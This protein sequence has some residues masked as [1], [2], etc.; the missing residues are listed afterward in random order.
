[1]EISTGVGVVPAPDLKA[2]GAAVAA[3]RRERGF[4]LDALAEAS[5][6]SRKSLINV[7][8]AH[9][10]ARLDTAHAIAHALGMPLSPLVDSLCADH[11]TPGHPA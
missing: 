3:A 9:K 10:I 11:D 7:E 5:G 4:S 6:V 1:M 8:K 2:F